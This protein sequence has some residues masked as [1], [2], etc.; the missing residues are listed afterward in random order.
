MKELTD[1]FSLYLP[2]ILSVVV[3]LVFARMAWKVWKNRP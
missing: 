2:D 1:F 3:V